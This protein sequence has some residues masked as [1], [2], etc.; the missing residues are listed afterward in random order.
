[1]LKKLRLETRT[2][3]VSATIWLEGT[4]ISDDH[5]G[6]LRT[7]TNVS[8]AVPESVELRMVKSELSDTAI[9]F[10]QLSRASVE[11]RIYPLDLSST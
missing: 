3:G 4:F 7:S 6:D 10:C 2:S 11:S 8:V 9:T 1:M 5:I